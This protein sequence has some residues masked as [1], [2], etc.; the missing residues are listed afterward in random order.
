MTTVIV[1]PVVEQVK[2]GDCIGTL[3]FVDGEGKGFYTLVDHPTVAGCR[4][5]L[6]MKMA[7]IMPKLFPNGAQVKPIKIVK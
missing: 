1:T 7:S 4:K 2:L 5:A 6:Q 3:Y